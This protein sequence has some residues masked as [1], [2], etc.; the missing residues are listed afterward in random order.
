MSIVTIS[1]MQNIPALRVRACKDRSRYS[2]KQAKASSPNWWIFFHFAK[3]E[4]FEGPGVHGVRASTEG[5]PTR[6]RASPRC[7]RL[8]RRSATLS[9]QTLVIRGIMILFAGASGRKV[10]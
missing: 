8:R 3:I 4:N 10:F 9:S 2:R 1:Y 7:C 5:A 6:K